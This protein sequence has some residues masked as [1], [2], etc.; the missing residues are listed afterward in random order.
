MQ[1]PPPQARRRVEELRARIAHHNY[2]YYVLDAPEI[3]DAEFDA[4][5]RELD[6]LERKRKYDEEKFC[7]YRHCRVCWRVVDECICK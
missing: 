7:I 2:A 3:S 1:D 6:Q 5:M 4:L